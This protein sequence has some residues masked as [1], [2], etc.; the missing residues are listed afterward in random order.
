MKLIDLTGQKFGRLT[1]ISL[2]P[3]QGKK[4]MWKCICDC[5]TE[6]NVAST[7]LRSGRVVSCGCKSVERISRLNLSHGMTGTRLYDIWVFMKH[8]CYNKND[9]RYNGYG[10]RGIRVC[11]EWK[12]NFLEFQKW[13]DESGYSD[14]LTIDRID[15]N[16]NYEPSNCRWATKEQQRNNTRKT[17]FVDFEGEKISLKNLSSLLDLNY[18]RLHRA[19]KRYGLNLDE[20]IMYARGEEYKNIK[21]GVK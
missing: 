15:V 17:V 5:G 16:G 2:A 7:H 6:K 14:E 3:N 18:S 19:Y 8:R 10:G 1:A 9:S 13:A 20:S 21:N 12:D 4:V 11:D